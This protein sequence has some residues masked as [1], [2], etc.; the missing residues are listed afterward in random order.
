MPAEFHS[1]AWF[2]KTLTS[3]K[4]A[5]S[6]PSDLEKGGVDSH[7]LFLGLMYREISR[8]IEIEPDVQSSAPVHLVNSKFGRKE[9]DKLESLIDSLA[10]PKL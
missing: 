8:S 3:L 5:L 7:L 9:L 6:K 1:L 10:H 4:K 2:S